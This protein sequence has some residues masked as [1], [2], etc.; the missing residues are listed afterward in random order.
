MTPY[1]P[2]L[3]ETA[4]CVGGFLL[5]RSLGRHLIRNAVV[6]SAFKAKEEKEVMRLLNLLIVLVAGILLTAIWGVKQSEI[7]IFA[8]SV[9]T[10]LGVAFFAEMSILSNITACLVLFF[11]HPIKIGDTIKV[12]DEANPIEGELIDI[13]YF[14][15]FIR[16]RDGGTVTMPNSVLLRSSFVIVNDLADRKP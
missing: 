4:V 6:R 15:V 9:I 13:T 1:A 5:I 3:I 11:Q 10:V 14:F 2:Q 8:T 7:L 12:L 16:T